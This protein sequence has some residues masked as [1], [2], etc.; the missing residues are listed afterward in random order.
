MR[1]AG[2]ADSAKRLRRYAL[3]RGTHENRENV[4]RQVGISKKMKK[5]F[6][7]NAEITK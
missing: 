4:N 3:A 5:I 2:K 7:L 1:F 6:M